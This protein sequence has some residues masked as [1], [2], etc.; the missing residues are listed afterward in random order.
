M[1]SFQIKIKR[2]VRTLAKHRIHERHNTLSLCWFILTL[3]AIFWASKGE[4]QV[5]AK[6][7]S[8]SIGFILALGSVDFCSAVW[9]WKTRIIFALRARQEQIFYQHLNHP[10]S[11]RG[12]GAECSQLHTRKLMRARRGA[13][14]KSCTCANLTFQYRQPH[15][16]QRDLSVKTQNA[17]IFRIPHQ[18]PSSQSNHR[19]ATM[20]PFDF[21]M[22]KPGLGLGKAGYFC[23][24]FGGDEGLP[25]CYVCFY[26]LILYH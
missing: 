16:L 26:S 22:W 13:T 18:Y 19:G 23:G 12:G 5:P 20:L 15:P 6:G 24:Y 2:T 1:N 10:S 8:P 3:F 25:C 4:K 17:A 11:G 7:F 9:L 14:G 21:Q